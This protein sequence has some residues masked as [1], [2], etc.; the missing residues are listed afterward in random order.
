LE[1]IKVGERKIPM[2]KLTLRCGNVNWET[3][4]EADVDL[5]LHLIKMSAVPDNVNVRVAANGIF[6]WD[7]NKW[8]KF[9]K[10][11]EN[12]IILNTDLELGDRVSVSTGRVVSGGCGRGWRTLDRNTLILENDIEMRSAGSNSICRS[13]LRTMTKSSKCEVV[14]Y[15]APPE[16]IGF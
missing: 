3:G 9:E 15:R 6:W 5:T 1:E 13:P 7:S 4:V 10:V 14:K 16:R 11:E 2:Q 8:E 12:K